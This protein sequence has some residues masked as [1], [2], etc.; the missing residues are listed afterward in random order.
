MPSIISKLF[1][2]THIP[3]VTDGYNQ[4][5]R[6]AIVDL[7][8]YAMFADNNIALSE[9]QFIADTEKKMTWAPH[10]DFDIYE[11]QSIG[12]VRGAKD[13]QSYRSGFFDSLKRR[14]GD[15]KTKNTALDLCSKLFA[16][17]GPITPQE[18]EALKTYRRVLF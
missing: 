2:R 13:D 4:E 5:Q 9:D 16:V 17:D 15:A 18:S 1:H 14:L 12:F 10:I 6:E 3:G 7:L 8:N 11:E